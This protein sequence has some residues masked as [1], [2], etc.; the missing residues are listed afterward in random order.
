[1]L[2]LLVRVNAAIDYGTY[3]AS[4]HPNRP[5]TVPHSSIIPIRMLVMEVAE[6]GNTVDTGLSNLMLTASP[7]TVDAA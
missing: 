2:W 7:M 6:V 5:T 3:V 4:A 1:M